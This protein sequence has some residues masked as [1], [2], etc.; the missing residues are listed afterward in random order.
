M[1]TAIIAQRG[2]YLDIRN[3]RFSRNQRDAGIEHL[4]WENRIKPLRPISYD[5][6]LGLCLTLLAASTMLF[7]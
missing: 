5:I 1:T 7:L 4:E 6:A 2:E 3:L